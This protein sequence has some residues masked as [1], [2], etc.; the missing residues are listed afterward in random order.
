LAEKSSKTRG[1]YRLGTELE[2]NA[3]R[4]S[5]YSRETLNDYTQEYDGNNI[6]SRA[7]ING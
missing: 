3:I 7:G 6:V 2:H 4:E 5:S 1:Y